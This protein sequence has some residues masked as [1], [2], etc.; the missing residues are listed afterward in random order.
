MI[1]WNLTTGNDELGLL[2]QSFNQMA[3]NLRQ[4]KDKFRAIYE[5]LQD[6][7]LEKS[8]DGTILEISPAV[9][10]ILGFK[11]NKLIGK[12]ITVL[13]KDKETHT[14]LLD[15]LSVSGRFV[16]M[17]VKLKDSEGKWLYG[18]VSAQICYD[19]ESKS[20]KICSMIRDITPR[21]IA[22]QKLNTLFSEN[23][24]LTKKVFSSIEEERRRLARDLHDEMGQAIAAIMLSAQVI[25][26]QSKGCSPNI[27]QQ[28][29]NIQEVA[30]SLIVSMRR[31]INHLRPSIL[32]SFGLDDTYQHT[33]DQWCS[34]HP[35]IQ[36]QF[37]CDGDFS[38]IPEEVKIYLYR[39]LQECLTNI[40]KHSQA[41]KINISLNTCQK[42]NLP[43]ICLSVKDN[44][45]GLPPKAAQYGTGISGMRERVVSVGGE[46]SIIS[47]GD[48]RGT[49]VTVHIPVSDNITEAEST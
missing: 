7:Y 20:K 49:R 3:A 44:G 46:F 42:N 31:F 23:R 17:E 29:V 16:D 37:Q 9:E 39:V 1:T 19:N 2:A 18:S 21:K 43:S 38:Q 6:I 48:P 10:D 28:A 5:N 12:D 25:Q 36:C 27:S 11:A 35:E 47:D 32:D 13:Y 14:K 15:K 33:I 30:N 40:S 26:L 41:D 45:I 8:L 24:K 22:E 34:L 4:N